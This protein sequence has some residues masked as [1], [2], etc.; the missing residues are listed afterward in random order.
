[1]AQLFEFK[2]AYFINGVLASYEDYLRLMRD[3][4]DPKTNPIKSL[5]V[6]GDIF[7]I[8]TY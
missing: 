2:R 7:D 6:H 8:I 4:Q 1:M 3:S 5:L